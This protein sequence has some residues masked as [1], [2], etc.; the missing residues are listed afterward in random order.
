MKTKLLLLAGFFSTACLSQTIELQQFASG[1]SSPVEVTNAGDNRLFVAERGG[2]IKVLNEDGSTNPTPF[3]NISNIISSGGERGLLG[4]AFHPDY[5][6]NGYFYVNY[7]NT[8]GNTVVARY[9]VSTEDDNIADAS[10]A[11]VIITIDQPMANHNGG[12]LRFGPDGY[13][14][15]SM[16][17]GGGGGDPDNR[18]QNINDLLGKLLRIDV[19]NGDPYSSPADN[20]FVGEDGADEIWAY[21]LRNAWKFSFD[22]QTGDLWIADVGQEIM[23]EINKVAG[24]EAG[25]NY[26]WRCYEG[27]EEYN[28]GCDDVTPAMVEMPFAEYDHDEGC[29]ITGGFVYRGNSYPSLQ[30]KYFFSDY[31]SSFI[32]VVDSNGAG[33]IVYLDQTHDDNFATFG[34]DVNNELYVAGLGGSGVIY[35]II[36]PNAGISSFETNDFAIYPNPA[37]DIINIKSNGSY[38]SHISIYDLS[39]KL[40]LNKNLDVAE[41]N[42][43]TADGL[44]SGFYMMTII[45]SDG[46]KHNY[47]LSIK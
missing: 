44:P 27:S 43:I 7:T 8:A 9:T 42:T 13:L 19:N 4:L 36:D 10:S 6:E 12:C 20:P 46:A 39:G 26:G 23:E 1:F 34:E 5:A 29:S 40:L 21:G 31:C 30:G 32:A 33:E 17:D 14:Y 16:G 38:A 25:V 15:I 28:G 45:D 2:A 41:T 11:S 18:A 24:T 35:K 47:K 37:S 22:S 3:L